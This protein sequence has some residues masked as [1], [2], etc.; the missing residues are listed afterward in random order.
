MDMWLLRTVLQEKGRGTYP[1][2]PP[3]LAPFVEVPF[4]EH[5]LP[6]LPGSHLPRKPQG[7][8][9]FLGC[10]HPFSGQPGLFLLGSVC[11]WFYLSTGSSGWWW[12]E[13]YLLLQKCSWWVKWPLGC[14][15]LRGAV[16]F[17]H[18]TYTLHPGMEESRAMKAARREVGLWG[19]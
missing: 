5:Q 16:T 18:M 9:P 7:L 2:D 6:T 17:I 3:V 13:C 8:E 11:F 15:P 19:G 14:F 1:L 12:N 4:T 10:C